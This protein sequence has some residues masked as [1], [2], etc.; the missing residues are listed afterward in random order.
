MA[1]FLQLIVKQNEQMMFS[2]YFHDKKYIHNR[3]YMLGYIWKMNFLIS[4][5]ISIETNSKRYNH[6]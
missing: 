6:D 2:D 1:S 3:K 4:K 5:I